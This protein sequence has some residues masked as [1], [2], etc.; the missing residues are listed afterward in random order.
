MLRIIESDIDSDDGKS[1]ISER[2]Q[3][4]MQLTGE[5]GT[6]HFRKEDTRKENA[7]FLIAYLDDIPYGCGALRKISED[8]AEIKRIYAK[9]YCRN[10][11]RDCARTGR[12]GAG[13]WL[14]TA[15]VGNKSAECSCHPV[16]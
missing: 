4:L 9:K 13:I 14:P 12:K 1:L 2:N 15:P 11:K 7:V 10:R 6:R 5:D 3:V 16:L 8:T